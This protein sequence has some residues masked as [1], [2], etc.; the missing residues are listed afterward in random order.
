VVNPDPIIQEPLAPIP[1]EELPAWLEDLRRLLK[2]L[3][4]WMPDEIRK[5]VPVEVWW[6]LYLIALLAAL[7]IV[8]HFLKGVGRLLFTRRR[9]ERDWDEGQREDL[10]ECPMPVQPPG[11]SALSVYHVPVRVRLVVV[12]PLGKDLEIGP[13]EVPEL[14]NR[15]FPE[16][17]RVISREEPRI[18][19][20]PPQLSD[21][22]FISA[23]HRRM[24][25]P[26]PDGQSSHWILVAGRAPV[27]KQ[28]LLLG[29]ALWSEQRNT[30]GRLTLEPRQWLEVLRLRGS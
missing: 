1:P 3:T 29:L 15:V 11:E 9:K 20:W 17:G 5:I 25:K 22:G 18:L 23:F 24:V 4:D 28:T 2:P 8:G 12:A 27:G 10:E 7:L 19:V 21:L 14:L 26:E 16:L 6:L 13:G 30:I